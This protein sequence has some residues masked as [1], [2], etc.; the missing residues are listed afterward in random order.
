MRRNARSVEKRLISTQTL[1]HA[2]SSLANL[3][4]GTAMSAAGDS[5]AFLLIPRRELRYVAPAERAMLRRT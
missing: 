5:R 4:A 3:P 1:R 2:H